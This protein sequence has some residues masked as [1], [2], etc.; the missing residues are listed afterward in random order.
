MT[1]RRCNKRTDLEKHDLLH[2]RIRLEPIR[3]QTNEQWAREC[4]TVRAVTP[5]TKYL[6]G[7]TSE[8]TIQHANAKG[9][10]LNWG[11]RREVDE[12]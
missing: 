2:W 1:S 10:Q 6:R 12:K 8:V 7:G 9:V 5:L 11:F 3:F 4:L